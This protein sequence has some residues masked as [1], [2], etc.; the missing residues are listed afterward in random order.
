MAG[1]KF[2]LINFILVMLAGF[3]MQYLGYYYFKFY[4]MKFPQTFTAFVQNLIMSVL[5]LT[6]LFSRKNA[7]G[8]SMYIAIFKLLGT[9]LAAL[10][11]YV[12]DPTYKGAHFNLYYLLPIVAAL[13]FIYDSAYC[14]FLYQQFKR[15]GK[16]PFG[17]FWGKDRVPIST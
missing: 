3:A 16:N 8:Q 4:G 5:F 10:A 14:Y 15:E 6:M 17:N 7:E 12:I 1:G 11:A 9:F 2:F 13:T